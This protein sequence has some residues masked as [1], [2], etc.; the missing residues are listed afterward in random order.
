[1]KQAVL[2][3]A[4]SDCS[5]GAGIQAD[6]KTFGAHGVYGMSI[7]LSV[8]A[9]NTKEVISSFDLPESNISDQFSAVFSDIPPVAIKIG[10]L[11]S[12]TIIK[13]VKENLIKFNAKN[14][15][16]DPVMFAKNG[17][18]LMPNEIRS[19]FKKEILPLSYILTPNL[20]EANDLCGFNIKNLED[21]KKAC[22][23][24]NQMGA[25]NVLLKGGHLE[26]SA[27]DVF[28][29]GN[30]FHILESKRIDS[31]NTHGTGCS[32]SSAIA[33]NLA[34]GFSPLESSKLA[35]DYVFNAILKAHPL[36]SGNGP[37]NHFYK[38]SEK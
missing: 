32:L 21:M 14:I 33:A 28:F 8:V 9:E 3:I 6:L 13:A 23:A 18:A 16:I 10:M 7:I 30:E 26:D 19:L 35:K 17:F 31:K 29:D 36:G 12:S 4:G 20:P 34:L 38:F 22:I 2:S 24:L 15:V 25:K 37:I 27:D 11:G 5:G 1:M